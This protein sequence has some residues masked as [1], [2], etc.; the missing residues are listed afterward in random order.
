MMKIIEIVTSL[1]SGGA[2]RFVVDLSNEL[3][4]NNEVVLIILKNDAKSNY[5]FYRKE[6]LDRIK[7]INLGFDD[8]RKL[9]YLWKVYKIIKKENP[10]IVHLH[11]VTQYC[12]IAVLL[13]HNKIKFFQTVHNDIKR[14]GNILYYKLAFRIFGKLG[15]MKFITI[16]KTNHVDMCNYYPKCENVLIYN[17]RCPQQKTELFTTVQAEVNLLKKTENTIVFIHVARC[18]EQ[19]NQKLLIDS[20]NRLI[21]KQV[22]AILLIIGDNFDSKEGKVLQAEACSDIHFLGVRSNIFDYL[23][24]SDIF[25]LSSIYEGMPISLIEAMQAGVAIL[26]TPVCGVIDVVKSGVNGVISSGFDECSF[27]RAMQDIATNKN[28]YLSAA[29]TKEFVGSFSIKETALQY[30]KWFKK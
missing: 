12:A 10:Q 17:G 11:S 4:K 30:I 8:G 9:S 21:K 3:S 29:K 1:A 20:F 6:V 26:S 23:L 19:K 7:Y 22:D 16:S 13:L 2:E 14:I 5:G 28:K 25:V 15:W 24:C 27:Y 18:A